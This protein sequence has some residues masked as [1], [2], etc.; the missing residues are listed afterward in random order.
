MGGGKGSFLEPK[1]HFS[2]LRAQSRPSTRSHA[3]A[4]DGY[5]M[6]PNRVGTIVEV[7]SDGN[8]TPEW[9]PQPI[10]RFRGGWTTRNHGIDDSTVRGAVSIEPLGIA[11]TLASDPPRPLPRFR[12]Q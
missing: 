5:A 4:H 10:G 6:G 7:H 2:V 9:S 8:V 3:G 11:I 12:T 1:V